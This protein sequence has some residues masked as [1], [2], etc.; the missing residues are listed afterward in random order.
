MTTR[1]VRETLERALKSAAQA[2]ILVIGADRLDAFSTDWTTVAGFAVGGFVL[3]VL[4][5]LASKPLGPDDGS[6]SVV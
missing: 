5:S 1:F 6:P 3:S 2:A 4:T